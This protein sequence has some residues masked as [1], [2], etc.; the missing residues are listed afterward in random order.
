MYENNYTTWA[1]GISSRYQRPFNIQKPKQIKNKSIK[2]KTKQKYIQKSVNVIHHI[3]KLK[4]NNYMIILADA[5]KLTK[6]S[7]QL[8]QKPLS[9]LQ[10]EG[11]F[12]CLRDHIYKKPTAIIIPHGEKLEA[13]PLKSGIRQEYLFSPPLS[14]ITV[15]VL[16]HSVKQEKVF[17]LERK[18]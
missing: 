18:K 16:P 9:K 17:R 4:K 13:F 14:N 1:G 10:I 11:Y 12:P 7:T 6:S 5:K 8:W 2:I 15:E 3:N